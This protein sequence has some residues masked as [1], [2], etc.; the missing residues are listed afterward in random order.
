MEMD[1]INFTL[2]AEQAV[3][4][5][6]VADYLLKHPPTD[7]PIMNQNTLNLASQAGRTLF[8]ASMQVI[9]DSV[10]PKQSGL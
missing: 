9:R 6:L 2:P 3:A 4:L 1:Q 7:D 10:G 5:A 8:D